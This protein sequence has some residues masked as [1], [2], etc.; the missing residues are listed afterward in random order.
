MKKMCVT[1]ILGA[2]IGPAVGRCVAGEP[3][4]AGKTQKPFK[5]R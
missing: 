3:A 1:L 2:L 5:G 4:N